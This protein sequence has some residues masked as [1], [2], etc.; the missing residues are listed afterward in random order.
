MPTQPTPLNDPDILRRLEHLEKRLASVEFDHPNRSDAVMDKVNER[1]AKLEEQ[2]Q[3]KQD[4]I[5]N[6][7]FHSEESIR[8]IQKSLGSNVKLNQSSSHNLEFVPH[9]STIGTLNVDNQRQN[10]ASP[11]S[12]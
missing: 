8:M 3:Q 7:L 2:V 6:Y 5:K 4:E 11:S 10:I 12:N 1:L 9:Q